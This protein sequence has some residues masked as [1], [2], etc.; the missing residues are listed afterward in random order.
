MTKPSHS[1]FNKGPDH[2]APG[3]GHPGRF[4]DSTSDR[5][6]KFST[7]QIL[8]NSDVEP[9]YLPGCPKPGARWSGPFET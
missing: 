3:L 4:L 9:K 7:K 8:K 5:Q 2:L 6:L 1:V